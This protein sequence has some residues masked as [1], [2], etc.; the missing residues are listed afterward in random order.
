MNRAE[1]ARNLRYK[2]PALMLIQRDEIIGEINAIG[3]ECSELEYAVEDDDKLIAVFDGDTDEMGEFRM[4]FSA[5]SY[6]CERL[7]REL[8]DTYVTEHFD[9][10]FVGSLG[11]AYKTI[12]YDS[13]EEDYYALTQF[14]AELAHEVSG[15]RLMG[16]TKE[17]LIATAGQCIG[18]MMCLLDIRHSYECLKS[19]LDILRDERSEVMKNVKG[20]SDAYD[21]A[22]ANPYD[23]EAKRFYDSML[24]R[25]PD[26]AWVQ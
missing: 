13:Y 16:L 24:D 5:L 9:D 23:R 1:K 26:A 4:M 22:Q 12:G 25:L 2:R 8:D 3:E 20:I 6:K 19:T 7:S 10:F 15:K 17:T 11:S 14:E 18:I 21:K